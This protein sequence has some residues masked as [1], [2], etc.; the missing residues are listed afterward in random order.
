MP[1]QR[2]RDRRAHLH[3]KDAD[4]FGDHSSAGALYWRVLDACRTFSC[5]EVL[6]LA[7]VMQEPLSGCSGPGL[8]VYL[9]F[10]GEIGPQAQRAS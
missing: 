2:T 5:A 8:Y 4:A 1:I 6:R 9:R 3:S 7:D 10:I